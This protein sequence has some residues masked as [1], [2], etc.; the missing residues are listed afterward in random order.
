MLKYLRY[1]VFIIPVI[2]L[3]A[4]L[5]MHKAKYANDPEYIY[6]VNAVAICD[7]KFVGHIDNPGTTVMQLGAATIAIK[8]LFSN[9]EKETL[10]NNVFKEPDQFVRAIRLVFLILNSF[11][12][13]LL[14]WVAINKTKSLWVA[15]LLQATTFITSN[16]LDHIWTKMSPEPILF[17]ITCLYVIAILYFYAEKEKNRWKYVLL[18]ALLAGAG[19]ATKATFLPLIVFPFVVLPT[20]KKKIFYI[21]GI[22]PSF[23]LF[24]I[25]AIPEY[26]GMYYCFRR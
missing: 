24:T 3:L 19:L 17:L 14:G 5:N 23:V 12:L 10:V 20:V 18:F 26:E 2:F 8:H 13:L 7:G 4:G 9:S 15:I 1:I 25:P 6:L 16:T 11:V 21:I 22:I